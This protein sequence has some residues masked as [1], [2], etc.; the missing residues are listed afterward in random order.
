MQADTQ[1]WMK[2]GDSM[3]LHKIFNSKFLHLKGHRDLW[4]IGRQKEVIA[5]WIIVI[6]SYNESKIICNS[7]KKIIDIFTTNIRCIVNSLVIISVKSFWN[8]N[9]SRFYVNKCV[10]SV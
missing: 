6:V 7:R 10:V 5:W 1:S 2:I 3:V 8:Y 9:N 4:D